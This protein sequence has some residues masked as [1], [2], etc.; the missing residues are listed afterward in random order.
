MCIIAVKKAGVPWLSYDE[1]KQ[2]FINNPDGA[3]IAWVSEKGLH[4]KKG[5]FSFK[6]L[7]LDISKLEKYPVLLHCR[8]ATHGS[9]TS[10]NCHPFLLG[11]NVAIAHNGIIDMD[12]LSLEGDITDSLAFGKRYIE[13]FKPDSLEHYAIKELLEAAI[14]YYNKIAILKE[15]GKFI[16]LNEE[17]GVEY[18]GIWFSN[19]S[20]LEK[21]A[22]KNIKHNYS[23]DY[24]VD[25]FNGGYDSGYSYRDYYG[26][27]PEGNGN[28]GNY[29][30]NDTYKKVCAD[31]GCFEHESSSGKLYKLDGVYVCFDC[32]ELYKEYDL[33]WADYTTK[34]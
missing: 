12:T 31:C 11:N 20:Y 30:G 3:G 10:D 14:G 4:V 8:L 9:I 21:P 7:W 15:D 26:N 6:K 18:K 17:E 2:C 24:T 25:T 29:Y 5:Y 32:Y 16:I 23:N 13:P 34:G 27:N 1:M 22:V 19:S 33:P 28:Y